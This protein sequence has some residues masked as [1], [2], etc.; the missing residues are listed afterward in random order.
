VKILPRL[1][2]GNGWVEKEIVASCE[3]VGRGEVGYAE[4]K[5]GYS[6]IPPLLFLPESNQGFRV[7]HPPLRS[8]L[9]LRTRKPAQEVPIFRLH[10]RVRLRVRG[11]KA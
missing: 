11:C 6:S 1:G 2:F 7:V 3:W 8:I 4:G 5:A 10:E 9:R